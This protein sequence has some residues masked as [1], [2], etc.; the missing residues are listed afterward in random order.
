MFDDLDCPF[1]VCA[2]SDTCRQCRWLT[3]YVTVIKLHTCII[4]CT[5][6]TQTN[7]GASQNVSTGKSERIPS[8]DFRAWDKYDAD[9]GAESVDSEAKK[10]SSSVDVSPK[11][12]PTELSETG[13]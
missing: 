4:S 8:H 2:L 3:N 5:S 6:H 13:K 7:A 1:H 11:G 10:S 9:R 12:I